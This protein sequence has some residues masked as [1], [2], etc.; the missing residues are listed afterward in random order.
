MGLTSPPN[1]AAS[2]DGLLDLA[3]PGSSEAAE[4]DAMVVG[5][6]HDKVLTNHQTT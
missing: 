6:L 3:L 5:P 4:G 2:D 1:D